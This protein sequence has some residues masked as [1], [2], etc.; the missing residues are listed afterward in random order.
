MD[1]L[2]VR[3]LI[4]EMEE[5]LK[6]D[7][8][9]ISR[10]I[11]N[12]PE[13]SGQE[14]ISSK[15]LINLMEQHGFNATERYCNIP[16]SFRAELGEADGPVI[17]FLAEYDAL[18]GY[19][20]NGEPAHACGH[21][22][23]SAVTAGTAI[24]LSKMKDKFKGKVVLIGTPAEETVGAK[25]DLVKAGAFE[26]VDIC[27]QAHLE[28]H[29]NISYKALAMDSLEF[30]FRGRATH[31]S[32]SPHE[33]INALDAVQLTFAGIN[34]LRQ[35]VKSD[36]RI[37]GIVSEGGEAPNIVPENAA[38]KFY[39]RASERAYLNEVTERV[40]N[41]A[42][43]A[44]LM[45]GAKLTYSYFENSFDNIINIP[46]LI[47][48]GKENLEFVGIKDIVY[49]ENNIASGSSDIGN[50]SQVC[51]TLYM[52]IDLEADKV[53]NVHETEILDYVDSPYS[54]KKLHQIV[55]AMAGISMDLYNNPEK[56]EEIKEIHRARVLKKSMEQK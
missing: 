43:G 38:C 28:S 45:T 17:A 39:V 33:G 22:W 4:D 2:Q 18:P 5:T 26:D 7:L 15:Y 9:G 49:E 11:F 13:L 12:N 47:M 23:I 46:E 42:K 8:E 14:F 52:D 27:M 21:N 34:A 10:F 50:V 3:A 48:I 56:V 16:T 32:V 6:V 30:K 37:H 25:A 29:T 41:C 19:G 35:H 54:Y 55:K 1:K 24:V 51:P 40:I 53:V 44:E 20:E 36:V 31:A